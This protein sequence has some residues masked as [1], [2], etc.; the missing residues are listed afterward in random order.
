MVKSFF[1]K[2]KR[3]YENKIITSSL[4]EDFEAKNSEEKAI[5]KEALSILDYTLT[6]RK[7][8]VEL[9]SSVS[10]FGVSLCMKQFILLNVDDKELLPKLKIISL[11]TGV[12]SARQISLFLMNNSDF[13]ELCENNRENLD[14]LIDF[15]DKKTIV[16][17]S[18]NEEIIKRILTAPTRQKSKCICDYLLYHA[19]GNSDTNML[20]MI[21]GYKNAS[22]LNSIHE[23]A[24]SKGEGLLE[25]ELEEIAVDT[26]KYFKLSK[27]T[28]ET[29]FG[30]LNETDNGNLV[31]YGEG[32]ISV[33]FGKCENSNVLSILEGENT[34]L[35]KTKVVFEDSDYAVFS[36]GEM[37]VVWSRLPL[38]KDEFIES[39]NNLFFKK[40]TNV[41]F[42]NDLKIKFKEYTEEKGTKL[43]S[44]LELYD[45]SDSIIKTLKRGEKYGKIRS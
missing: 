5:I 22:K 11:S 29:F 40:L 35:N 9:M 23:L 6:Q 12:M 2:A 28:K 37:Q 45:E 38:D 16:Y 36:N 30:N 34:S 14:I 18:N 32:G 39:Y 25:T 41:F 20:R 27:D 8:I 4:M 26:M 44:C 15:L 7:E 21:T 24:F 31:F 19:R 1:K 43:F 42:T 13:Y 17:N 3:K 10:L 33:T